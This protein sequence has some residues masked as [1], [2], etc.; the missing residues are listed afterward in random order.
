MKNVG[1][2]GEGS[3]L[4]RREP[5]EAELRDYV[6]VKL[7]LLGLSPPPAEVRAGLLDVLSG[8]IEQYREKERLLASHLWPAD[9]RIQT[10]LFGSKRFPCLIAL[11]S[12]SRAASPMKY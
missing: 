8:F 5:S 9:Q 12:T 11:I 6:Q 4:S 2:L 1:Q 10:F 3:A 7:A